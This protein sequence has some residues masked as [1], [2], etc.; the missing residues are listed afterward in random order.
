M[1]TVSVRKK[2][3][4]LNDKDKTPLLIKSKTGDNYDTRFTSSPLKSRRIQHYGKIYTNDIFD[5]TK[6]NRQNKKS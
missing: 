2:M 4:I 3:T 1:E 6:G 5:H